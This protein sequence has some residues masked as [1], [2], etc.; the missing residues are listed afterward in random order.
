M[1]APDYD[2]PKP[3]F[4]HLVELRKRLI[5]VI[6][7]FFA[8]TGLC[9]YFAEP[10]FQFLLSPLTNVFQEYSLTGQNI[11]RKLIYTGLT[12]AFLT[13]L[14]IAAF[15]GFF[16]TFPYLAIQ[17]WYFA[18][19][20][21]FHH[22]RK[23]FRLILMATPFLF[24][25]GAAFAYYVIFPNAYRFFLSFE[26]M[27]IGGNIPIQLE[28]RVGEYLSFVMKLLLAFG[29]SFQLPVLLTVLATVKIVTYRGLIEKWRIATVIIFAVAAMITPPDMLSMI[30]LA[31]PL[32]I[33]YA[34]SILMIKFVES[35]YNEEKYTSCTT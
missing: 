13:Y 19:P 14:K 22:E 4:D 26:N 12:E 35:R 34:L 21:L 23:F 8:A 7:L 31:I 30:G 3:L 24:F 18:S 28:P 10:I 1:I 17:V 9:Y 16:I 32:L 33:L 20:A 6:C 29:I 11:T 27:G 5:K 25:L 2:T 15:S